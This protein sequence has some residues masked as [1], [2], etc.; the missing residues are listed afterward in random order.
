[1]DATNRDVGKKGSPARWH[2]LSYILLLVLSGCAT[3][4]ATYRDPNMDFGLVQTVAVL[5]F[6]NYSRDNIAGDRVRDVFVTMLQ[7]TGAVYV[8]PTGEVARGISRIGIQN[9][10]APTAEE[11]ARFCTAVKA[12]T[13]ITGAVREYGEVRSGS[14]QANLISMSL[15]MM[16]AQTGKVVWSASST[17]GGVTTS[18]RLFGGGGDPMNRITEKAIDDLLDK[19]FRGKD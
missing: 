3:T 8:V 14:S 18:D 13:V 12:D 4:G 19:L 1:M 11:V 9:P 2:A 6:N 5:P 7:G 17:Q 16:E 15:Q 10:A